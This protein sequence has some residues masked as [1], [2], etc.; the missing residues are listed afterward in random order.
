MTDRDANGRFVKGNGAANGN[1]GGPGRPPKA[2]E[3]KYLEIMKGTITFS[4][5]KALVNKT[6]TLA[7]KGDAAARKALF[8][9]I[10]GPPTQ[11]LEHSGSIE[12]KVTVNWDAD[13]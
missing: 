13:E 8:D 7:M 11:K 12:Q 2:R 4:E 5:F 6:Y 1:N 3:E 9:Y 10:L